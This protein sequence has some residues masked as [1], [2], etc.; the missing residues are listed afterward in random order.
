MQVG[1]WKTGDNQPVLANSISLFDGTDVVDNIESSCSGSMCDVCVQP[2][3]YGIPPT[4]PAIIPPFVQPTNPACRSGN[5][6]KDKLIGSAASDFDSLWF[7]ILA[8]ISGIGIIITLI[9]IGLLVWRW[10]EPITRTLSPF[11][12]LVI[13]IGIIML[14]G[15][16]PIYVIPV[17]ESICAIQRV[18]P[19]I[20][21]AVCLSGVFLQV[22]RHWRIGRRERRISGAKV[23]FVNNQSQV[24]LFL[25]LFAF[26][27]IMALEWIIIQPPE[28]VVISSESSLESS[29]ST[30]TLAAI[31]DCAYTREDMVTYFMFIFALLILTLFVSIVARRYSHVIS[32]MELNT[33]LACNFGK[34][35]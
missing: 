14:Y 17:S 27:V 1:S 35:I 20:A 16:T 7:I 22:M 32:V 23:S 30:P 33:L 8:I 13:L 21:L 31:L 24:V 2:P 18:Y 10:D 9:V 12:C 15:V 25:F 11:L 4:R 6:V 5:V 3:T 28:L 34:Y 26:Q 19:G 29:T